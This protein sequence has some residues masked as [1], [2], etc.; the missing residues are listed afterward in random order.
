VFGWRFFD[1]SQTTLLSGV[2][3]GPCELGVLVSEAS[4]AARAVMLDVK[5]IG[6][7]T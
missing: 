1:N 2:R 4:L 5:S 6:F 7:A 3:G